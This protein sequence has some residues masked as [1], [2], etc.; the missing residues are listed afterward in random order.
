MKMYSRIL[1]NCR[2]FNLNTLIFHGDKDTITSIQHSKIFYENIKSKSK[3]L[4]VVENGYH[5]IYKDFE[6]FE[7]FQKII[8]WVN[9]HKSIGKTDKRKILI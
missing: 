4:V 2:N 1:E 7:M 3:E 6:K 9:F 5:E 8:S